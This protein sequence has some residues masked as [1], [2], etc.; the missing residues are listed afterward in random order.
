MR[1]GLKIL[2]ALLVAGALM[3]TLVPWWLGLALH[4]LARSQGITFERYERVGYRRFRLHEVRR[5]DPGVVATAESLEID[6]PLLWAWRTC[7]DSLTTVAVDHWKVEIAD[8][9]APPP[10]IPSASASVAGVHAIVSRT[11]ASLARWVPQAALL[12]GELRIAGLAPITIAQIDL[13]RGVLTARGICVGGREVSLSVKRIAGDV[14]DLRARSPGDE[15]ALDLAWAGAQLHGSGTWHGQ[16]LRLQARFS[17]GSW[18]PVDAEV[19]AENWSLP[20]ARARMDD[21]Y[22]QLAG[23]AKLVWHEA[24]FDLSGEWHAAPKEGSNAPPMQARLAAHGDR[25]TVTITTFEVSAPFADAKLSAPVTLGFAGP[26][27]APPARLTLH[28]DLAKQS[29][30]DA[31]GAVDGSVEVRAVASASSEAFQL[32]CDGLRVAGFQFH[33]VVAQGVLQW[34]HLDLE[35]LEVALDEQSHFTARGGADLA[36]RTLAEVTLSGTFSPAWFQRW[37]PA[38][39]RW[40][41]AEVAATLSGPLAALLHQGSIK[42]GQVRYPPLK[43]L[44]AALVWRGRSDGVEDFNATFTAGESTLRILGAASSCGAQVREFQFQQDGADV[45]KLAAPATIAWAPEWRIADLRLDGAGGH[46]AVAAA[47]EGAELSFKAEAANIESTWARDWIVTTGPAWTV[48]ALNAEGRTEEGNLRFSLDLAGQVALEP[49]AAQVALVARGDAGGVEL[50]KLEIRDDTG[51]L[52]QAHGRVP[53][54]W[55]ARRSP[56][57][58]L[59]VE[60]ALNFDAE[61]Q[62]DSS[63]WAALAAPFGITLAAPKAR[64]RIEGTPAKPTGALELDVQRLAIAAP[65]HQTWLPA[66]DNITVR[67]HADRSRLVID[68]LS[69]AVEGQALR[70]SAQSPMDT[71][72]WVQLVRSP[73]SFDWSQAEA[74]VAIP[75]AD[76]RPVSEGRPQFPLAQGR[77]QVAVKLARGINLSGSLKLTDATTR[78]IPSVGVLQNLTVDLELKGRSVEVRS[79]SAQ[80]G[81]ET[82]TLSGSADL[83]APAAPRL[84]LK[85]AGKNLPLVR[86]AGLLI[87]SDLSLAVAT[88]AGGETRITGTVNLHDSLVLADLRQLLPTGVRAAEHA[89]P[90]FAVETEPFR[91]WLLD[92]AVRGPHG[93]RLHTAVLTGFATPSFQLEGTLGEPR[94]VGELTL[95]SGKI[96]FPFAA[97]QAQLAVVRLSKADPFHPQLRLNATARRYG[98]DLRLEGRGP[99]EQPILTLSSNPALTAEQVL[100][101]VMAGQA[102]SSS[103]GTPAGNSDRK[104][105]TVLGAY[106]GRGLFRDLGGDDPDRLTITS[107]EQ[108][109]Q[110]GGET[111]LVEYLLGKR[112]SLVGEYD[113]FDDYNVGLKWR[114]YSE[115]TTDD[116][117]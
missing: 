14:L 50:T 102:P 77:L 53:L 107:G 63:L 69:A 83:S 13:Q 84:E 68:S 86:R 3:L 110:S 100:L 96:L 46:L 64:L 2:L 81:G 74:E 51:L 15:A 52:A 65:A 6:T 54:S 26:L 99:A 113:E 97:F 60:G 4:P 32:A 39:V 42:I 18:L 82:A 55:S 57:L 5:Q 67:A 17:D 34:P 106:L 12:H 105:L 72:R 88:G 85:L 9:G 47:S 114:V 108:V 66:L 28:V 38:D 48:K 92:V 30:L 23:G 59:N 58:Q 27:Q 44:D 91:N 33:R 101:L 109:T 79:A 116:S 73:E 87:R 111:Y 80:L 43:S 20:A 7:R 45:L 78:P 35:K 31:S 22:G 112:W 41:T 24:K 70:A 62:P 115:G 89:P 1:R 98:Y 56:S 37:L 40:E 61:T 71:K 19:V 94:A 10:T 95:D 103:A 117:K 49:S 76:L 29:W 21:H 93:L 11:F 36:L 90:Y 16:P 104:R 8:S 75:G 25:S